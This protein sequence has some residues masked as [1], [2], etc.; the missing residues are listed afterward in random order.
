MP[1]D[2]KDLYTP[3]VPRRSSLHAPH[4]HFIRG[5][6]VAAAVLLLL[7]V[8]TPYFASRVH[9]RSID[10]RLAALEPLILEASHDSGLRP[11]LVRAVVRAESGGDPAAVS[12]V[13]ARG[14]MQVMPDAHDD[15]RRVGRLPDGDLFDP[16]Y[17]LRVGTTYLAHLLQRFE[18]DTRL[19]VAAYHMGPTRVAELRR[20][21]PR[22]SSEEL[23]N[24]FGGPQTRAYVKRVMA[25]AGG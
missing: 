18:G 23:V 20:S 15:A 3:L 4:R 25:R 7:I 24:R 2:R 1:P 8:A 10:A 19:A 13:K 14:L 17:N 9:E 16:A 5:W 22:L 11:E 6:L 12:P 21:H